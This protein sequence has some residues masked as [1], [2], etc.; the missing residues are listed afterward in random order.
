MK[1]TNL[2]RPAALMTAAALTLSLAACGEKETEAS[3]T[4][5]TASPE[6]AATTEESRPLCLSG[7][8]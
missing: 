6:T 8:L 2:T 7:G 3:S 5:E 1:L 4:A